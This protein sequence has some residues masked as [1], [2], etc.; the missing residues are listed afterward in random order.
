MSDTKEKLMKWIKHECECHYGWREDYAL[1]VL[2]GILAGAIDG[3][4]AEYGY[5]SFDEIIF[6]LKHYG[7]E[8]K[9]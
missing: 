6:D 1:E 2:I 5:A 8:V 7:V 9:A 4:D 3:E